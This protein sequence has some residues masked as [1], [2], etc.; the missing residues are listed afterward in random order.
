MQLATVFGLTCTEF[1][2]E[3]NFVCNQTTFSLGDQNGQAD[4]AKHD[5][6]QGWDGHGQGVLSKDRRA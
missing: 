5:L 3:V 1:G 6:P 2:Y 4:H